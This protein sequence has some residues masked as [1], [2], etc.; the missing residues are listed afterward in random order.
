MLRASIDA[1]AGLIAASG[2]A[3]APTIGVEATARLHASDVGGRAGATLAGVGAAVCAVRDPGGQGAGRPAATDTAAALPGAVR[4][5]RGLVADRK[6]LQQ[7]LHDQ[8]QA[9]CPG[10]SAP[11]GCGRALAVE[12]SIG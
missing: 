8:L 12:G 9:L 10:L 7:R 4:H 11:A 6:V 1:P 3:G 2:V 5:R